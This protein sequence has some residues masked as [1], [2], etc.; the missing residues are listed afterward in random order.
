MKRFPW[1]AA[2]ACSV[3]A[4]CIAAEGRMQK[5]ERESNPLFKENKI[6]N[7][8]PHM[9]WPEVE[10]ALQRTDLVLMPVGSVEQHGRHLP[11][12]TDSLAAI[13]VCKLI[14]QQ[15]E[16]VV[17]PSVLLGLSE[18]HMGFPGSL[19]L[20]PET[21]EAVVFET[22]RSL[23]RHGFR[24]ICVYNG[25]GGNT[26]AVASIIQR[27]NQETPATAVD[28]HQIGYPQKNSPY[29]DVPFDYHAGVGETS[30]MLYL[31]GSLVD[32]SAAENP[33][34]R[35]PPDVQKVMEKMRGDRNFAQVF[36]TMLMRPSETGKK[37][38]MREVSSNGVYTTGDVTDASA[39]QGMWE[40]DQVIA[41][42][43]RFLREW[44]EPGATSPF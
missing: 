11:L 5:R 38:S 43:V 6:K 40:I 25:H 36:N 24:K 16:A 33:E 22:A 9:T 41:T 4:V 35:L 13:E 8:L 1:L 32:M 14:A 34:I 28:L 18:H 30:W 26:T 39:E 2:L 17:A 20:R 21:F 3:I 19:T 10:A 12:G 7:Y 29:T 37:T 15:V 44:K 42:A 23:I 31:T 27:I